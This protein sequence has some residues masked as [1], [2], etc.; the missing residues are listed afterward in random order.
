MMCLGKCGRTIRFVAQPYPSDLVSDRD[1]SG[2]EE[3]RIKR[4]RHAESQAR[5]REYSERSHS[6]KGSF[7]VFLFYL[8]ACFVDNLMERFQS[9]CYFESEVGTW[10]WH[11]FQILYGA[12][13][14]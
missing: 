13:V 11:E 2:E 10:A 4:V 3:G 9:A 5:T 12:S 7:R 6:A 14:F 1:Y 8:C